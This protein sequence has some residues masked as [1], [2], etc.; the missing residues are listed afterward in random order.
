MT[1]ERSKTSDETSNKVYS[2]QKNVDERWWYCFRKALSY[3]EDKS[4]ISFFN[5]DAW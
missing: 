2:L 5:A 1:T 4:Q 3:V